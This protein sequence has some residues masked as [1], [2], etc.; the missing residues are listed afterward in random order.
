MYNGS[1]TGCIAAE[2]PGNHAPMG[3]PR[4]ESLARHLCTRPAARSPAPTA[5]TTTSGGGSSARRD[6]PAIPFD[7]ARGGVNDNYSEPPALQISTVTGTA[8]D[9]A[10][11]KEETIFA[12]GGHC[13]Y[14]GSKGFL[15]DLPALHEALLRIPLVTLHKL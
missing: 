4:L 8:Y 10:D 9:P 13:D 12:P 5:A 14:Y 3:H 2:R 15:S 7:G 11:F 1:L 6:R